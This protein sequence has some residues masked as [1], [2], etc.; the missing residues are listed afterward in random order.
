MAME[1]QQGDDILQEK[2]KAYR[3]MLKNQRPELDFELFLKILDMVNDESEVKASLEPI[4]EDGTWSSEARTF[5]VLGVKTLDDGRVCL[6]V[7]DEK[8]GIKAEKLY[9]QIKKA[10]K[11]STPYKAP[12]F[13][14]R[15]ED[16]V[17]LTDVYSH[18][19]VRE[20]YAGMP[21]DVVLATAR[22]KTLAEQA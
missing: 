8:H 13:F 16:E 4:N 20:V 19:L 3:E 10:F 22:K 17:V 11:H 1:S 12:V 7:S 15:G 6:R 9:E 18:A 14:V 2:I 21:S 5:A